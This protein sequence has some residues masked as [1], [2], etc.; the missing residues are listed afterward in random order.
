MKVTYLLFS[1]VEANGDIRCLDV[2]TL[3]DHLQVVDELA[4]I[5]KC[6]PVF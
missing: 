1:S 4:V 2:T 3:D 5:D 6:A